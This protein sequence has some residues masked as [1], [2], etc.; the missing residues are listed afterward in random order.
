MPRTVTTKPKSQFSKLQLMDLPGVIALTACLLLFIVSL[1]GEV[2]RSPG[3][4]HADDHMQGAQSTAGLARTSSRRSAPRCLWQLRSQCG[5]DTCPR[6]KLCCQ[7]PCGVYQ[8]WRYWS[9]PGE[10]LRLPQSRPGMLISAFR[11]S[12]S[13]RQFWG[14][15]QFGMSNYWQVVDTV[16]P[17]LVSARLLPQGV[18]ALV[19]GAAVQIVPR[20]V[21]RPKWTMVS[22]LSSGHRGQRIKWRY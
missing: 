19:G 16:T 14:P 2:V 1:T 18:A 4:P 20:V 15:T 11:C 17:L 7:C 10:S 9:L 21:D 13:P 8:M 5:S 22:G 12:L 3:R 6:S